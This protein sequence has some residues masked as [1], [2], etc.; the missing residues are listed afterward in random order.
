MSGTIGRP[1]KF[2]QERADRLT[3]AIKAG[4]TKAAACQ[5]AGISMDTLARWLANFADFAD[6]YARAEAEFEMRNVAVIQGAATKRKV[7][8]TITKTFADGTTI[9]EERVSHEFDWQAAAWLLE[10]R[11]Y[12]AW[13]KRDRLEVDG[14]VDV[15]GAIID[16]V[17]NVSKRALPTVETELDEAAN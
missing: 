15:A 13:G 16:I 7:T 8:K 6:A 11:R 1:S 3:K 9:V 14:S 12:E 17:Q 5:C 10:R 4:N 2:S